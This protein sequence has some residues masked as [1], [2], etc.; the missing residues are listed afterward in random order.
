[1]KPR[2]PTGG[3]P[4]TA[5]WYLARHAAQ[6]VLEERDDLPETP[7]NPNYYAGYVAAAICYATC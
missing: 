7:G 2:P 6:H 5:D 1:M 4:G 3:K